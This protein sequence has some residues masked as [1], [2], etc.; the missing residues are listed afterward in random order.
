MFAAV[1]ALV[2]LVT[3]VWAV[4]ASW[5]S[6]WSV[7]AKAGAAK[8]SPTA[9]MSPKSLAP[10]AAPIPDTVLVTDFLQLQNEIAGEVGI[11]ITPVGL[12]APTVSL[13]Q[14]EGGP[15]W[16]TI[17]VPL[18]IAATRE[19]DS[20]GV[21]EAMAA[22][23]TQSDNAAA[24]QIWVELGSPLAAAGK[25]QSVLAEAGD[26]TTVQSERVRAQFSAFG[27]TDWSLKN[28]SRFA[29]FAACD[30]RDGP[31]LDLMGRVETGQR[32][33]LGR[34]ANAQF[35]GGWG[36]S[37]DGN[38]LVRQFGLISTGAGAVSVAIAVQPDSGDFATGTGELSTI[39]GWLL[40]HSDLLPSGRCTA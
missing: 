24:E 34:I 6:H 4:G 7:S 25:V 10:A 38:Y 32:W 28:Q 40:D 37:E 36:P 19:I 14:L 12:G 31:V 35:K 27:Q 18:A 29:A 23:I 30:E 5:E 21:T 11:A 22:A 13:G 17:K 1:I 2:G 26:K 15:A 3:A 8:A 39:A 16:S 9:T 33:G 20:L